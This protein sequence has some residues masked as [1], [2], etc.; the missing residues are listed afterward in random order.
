MGKWPVGASFS[1]VLVLL[2]RWFLSQI[3]LCCWYRYA[4]SPLLLELFRS[5]SFKD[6]ASSKDMMEKERQGKKRLSW[7]AV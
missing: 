2:M 7:E 1:A 3:S 4:L 6:E 5:V